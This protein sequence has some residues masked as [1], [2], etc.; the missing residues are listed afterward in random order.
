MKSKFTKILNVIKDYR[1]LLLFIAGFSM[2][3]L[4]FVVR[5]M[6]KTDEGSFK[7]F[8]LGACLVMVCSVFVIINDEKGGSK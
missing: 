3:I 2:F 1:G 4:L 5:D 8:L 6:F 7:F